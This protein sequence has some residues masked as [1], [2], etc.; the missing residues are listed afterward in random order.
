MLWQLVH[1]RY[2]AEDELHALFNTTGMSHL[3][4]IRILIPNHYFYFW[5]LFIS[6]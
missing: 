1:G 3:K 2:T 6:L 4:V 5:V